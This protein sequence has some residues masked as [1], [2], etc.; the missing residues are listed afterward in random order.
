MAAP[1]PVQAAMEIADATHGSTPCRNSQPAITIASAVTDP[2]DRSIPPEISRMVM[3]MTTMPSTAKTRVIARMF[4]QVRK[5]GEAKDIT[6]HSTRMI[7]ISPIS[8]ARSRRLII[9]ASPAGLPPSFDIRA[10][11]VMA[12]LTAGNVRNPIRRR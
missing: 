2:T 4:T 8:R 6:T 10:T 3:P 5:Y 1:T 9:S 12:S 11:L 7:A